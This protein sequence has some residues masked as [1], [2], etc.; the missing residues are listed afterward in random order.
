MSRPGWGG[1]RPGAGR[2]RT[3]DDLDREMIGE[4]CEAL[5]IQEGRAAYETWAARNPVLQEDIAQ[6]EASACRNRHLL[7]QV[8]HQRMSGRENANLDAQVKRARKDVDRARKELVASATGGYW[9]DPASSVP[10]HSIFR[11][12]R[13]RRDQI[14]RA[15][16]AKWAAEFGMALSPRMVKLCWDQ[17]RATLA[18]E[19]RGAAES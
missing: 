14:I 5:W 3:L 4:F 15:A 19:A 17:Y 12:P 11:R 18:A 2:R 9:K 8:K 1:K 7:E 6:Y 10:L 13:G 16:I